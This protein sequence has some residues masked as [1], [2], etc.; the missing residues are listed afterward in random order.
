VSRSSPRARRLMPNRPPLVGRVRLT[1]LP[2]LDLPRQSAIVLTQAR[3]CETP[4]LQWGPRK[5]L[6]ARWELS[7][8]DATNVRCFVAHIFLLL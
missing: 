5:H 1:I 7:S 6:V 2:G 3:Q 8:F 4:A